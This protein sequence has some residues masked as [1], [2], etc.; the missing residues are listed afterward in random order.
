MSVFSMLAASAKSGPWVSGRNEAPTNVWP[1]PMNFPVTLAAAVP[2]VSWL[3]KLC[4][5]TSAPSRNRR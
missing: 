2:S 1:L 5:C 4:T 3:L